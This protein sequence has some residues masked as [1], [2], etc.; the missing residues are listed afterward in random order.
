[1]RIIKVSAVA[2]AI[3]HR[4][5]VSQSEKRDL[6][7][8]AAPISPICSDLSPSLYFCLS[9]DDAG[10]GRSETQGVHGEWSA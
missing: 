7:R 4:G 10:R 2:A 3:A 5:A 9:Q 8:D 6:Q 1:M